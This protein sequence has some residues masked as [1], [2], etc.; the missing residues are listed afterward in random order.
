MSENTS[1]D[2]SK[3]IVEDLTETSSDVVGDEEAPLKNRLKDFYFSQTKCE[4]EGCEGT[5]IH[6]C[7][8]GTHF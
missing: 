4:F 7:A 2:C 3:E 6:H 1:Y 5:A 8:D